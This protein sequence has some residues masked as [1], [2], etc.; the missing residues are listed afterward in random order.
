MN[1][2]RRRLA[3]LRGFDLRDAPGRLLDGRAHLLRLRFRLE[4]RVVAVELELLALEGLQARRE[5]RRTA[6]LE[7]RVERPVLDRTE[8]LDLPLPFA[9]DAQR[10]RLD[11]SGGESPP[12]LLPEQVGN[13]VPDEAVDDAPGLLRVDEPPV[14][15]ARRLHRGEHGALGDL[16]EADPLEDRPLGPRLQGFLEVPG[17]RLALAVRVGREV[18]GRGFAG[19][20]LELPER[21]FL[22]LQDLVRRFVAVAPIDAQPLLGQVP[23]VAIGREHTKVLAEELLERLR[24]GR[25]FDDDEGLARRRLHAMAPRRLRTFIVI[26]TDCSL[27]PPGRA[28]RPLRS[29]QGGGNCHNPDKSAN[30]A[31]CAPSQQNLIPGA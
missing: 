14:D 20:L 11:A 28:A 19:G 15:L 12:D 5:L 8:R 17:D 7:V 22:A 6:R 26:A 16:V 29:S 4:A 27:L 23:H 3:P 13:L 31:A 24:L 25:R 2:R 9:D 1:G 21:L 30:R 10:H 18:D